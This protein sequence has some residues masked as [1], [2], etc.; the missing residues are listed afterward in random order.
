MVTLFGNLH[1]SFI[2]FIH[3]CI[4]I[5]GISKEIGVFF[6]EFHVILIYKGLPH[7]KQTLHIICLPP[8]PRPFIKEQIIK[9][10]MDLI[11][12]FNKL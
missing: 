4:N 12:H 10:F 8:T 7:E 2:G 3:T 9:C 5:V 1:T 6:L 11:V